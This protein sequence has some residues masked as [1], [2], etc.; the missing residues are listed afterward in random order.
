MNSKKSLYRIILLTTVFG[1]SS[2]YFVKPQVKEEIKLKN[3]VVLFLI[4]I[5]GLPRRLCPTLYPGV[6]STCKQ[7][8]SLP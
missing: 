7:K 8:R 2:F 1:S 3:G 4:P 5:A 6:R